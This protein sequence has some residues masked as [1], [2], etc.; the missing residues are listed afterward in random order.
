MM[1]M[2]M[3][4]RAAAADHRLAVALSRSKEAAEHNVQ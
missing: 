3:M 2:M 1:M 4:I